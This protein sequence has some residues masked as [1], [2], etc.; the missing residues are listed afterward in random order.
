MKIENKNDLEI[1]ENKKLLLDV[2]NESNEIFQIDGILN[3]SLILKPNNSSFHKIKSN[4]L[5]IPFSLYFL[6][7][8]TILAIC[9]IIYYIYFYDTNSPNFTVKTPEFDPGILNN[10]AYQKY[11]FD[12]GL[13]V[14]LIHDK[15]FDRDG[16][17]IVIE[18]GYLEPNEEGLATFSTNLLST[19]NFGDLDNITILDYYFGKFKYGTAE[20]F[21]NFRF[22]ILNNGFKKFL[23]DFS[24]I[25]NFDMNINESLFNTSKKRVIEEIQSEYNTKKRYVDYR[26]KHLLEYLVYGFKNESNGDILPEGNIDIISNINI[27]YISN[28]IK[29]FIDPSKIKIVLFSKYKFTISSKYMKNYFKYLTNMESFSDKININT[30]K[31]KKVF[32]TSQIFYIKEN[33]Y[34][35]NYIN[36]IYY[37]DKIGNENYSEL[38]HKLRY[39]YYIENFFKKLKNG[40]LYS[41]YKSRIKSIYV[42]IPEVVLKSRIKFSIYIYLNSLEKVN[43]IIYGTYQYMNKIVSELIEKGIQFDRYQ[44]I[45]NLC[46]NNGTLS[47]KSFD[48]I[49]LA[50]N[51]AIRLIET[52]DRIKDFFDWY[53]VPSI[54]DNNITEMIPYLRQLTPNN[55]VVILAI[56]DK[57]RQKLTC[58]NES[59]FYQNCEYFKN[60]FNFEKTSYYDVE[61]I[62]DSF[63]SAL[64]DKSLNEDKDKNNFNITYE[65]NKYMSTYN[66]IIFSDGEEKD[67]KLVDY[68][69]SNTLNR[70]YF[71]K[72]SNFK[73]PRV[74]I[75]FNLYHPYLRPNNTNKNDTKCNYF[76]LLEMFSAIKRKINEELSDAILAYAQIDFYQSENHLDIL[77]FC[78][79][80]Q[81]YNITQV[82]KK[83]INDT[84][85]SSSD[86]FTNNE[87][88][89]NEAFDDYLIFDNSDIFSISRTYFNCEL[90]HNLYNIYE[91][92]LYDFENNH[93]KKCIDN[94]KNNANIFKDLTTFII[95]IYIYGYYEEDKAFQIYNLFNYKNNNSFTNILDEV[96]ILI[97]SD[98]YTNWAKEIINFIGEK[99]VTINGSIFNK[100]DYGNFGI[101]YRIFD[102]KT[103]LNISIFKTI[104]D[105]I[106][107]N[108][109]SFLISNDMFKY[110]NY[111]FELVFYDEN[112]ESIIPN[113][114]LVK[115]EWNKLTINYE[116]LLGDVD[117]IGNR[118][119][120]LIKNF[121]LIQDKK[122][123]SLYEKGI[124]EIN[125]YDY[126]GTVI[127][128]Y[129]IIDE[130]KR[131]YKDVNKFNE[132]ALKD[133]INYYNDKINEVPYINIFTSG[134]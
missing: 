72:N 115:D 125:D 65:K 45:S 36:I 19:L 90:K 41:S 93:Y 30:K 132:A 128:P 50:V 78:F 133:L 26:Q 64:I 40:T 69:Y 110:K 114:D 9:I 121:I 77:V 122:Q 20:N 10:R 134:N 97:E 4:L 83:A 49:E 31:E 71:K 38:N 13:E 17:A 43:D 98:N 99:S 101:S 22:D 85:W 18:K 100:N 48:T 104:I 124:S 47:E 42:D 109:D 52:G 15:D 68:N 108:I 76:L 25:L 58:N 96:N 117:I 2:N 82:I 33:Y 75:K 66:D 23:R 86:F 32:N 106:N 60:D 53:C 5:K 56:R 92:S 102:D 91:F 88:Y 74:L 89:K 70:F 8:I 73:V 61:Y 113:E 54:E 6:I 105:R 131:I 120:Y 3:E 27:T 80:D 67:I 35:L 129:N 123:T 127:D 1:T 130:Y 11:V 111:I 29:N 119:Y 14:M 116:S 87:I 126:K 95:D 103:S 118:L 28:Y 21:I 7:I 84:D 81:A 107:K 37:I 55:S 39:L 59:E 44:E 16:G 51:N 94:A 57:D 24:S 79:S 34:G 46:I 62:R 112:L 12:N 63:D